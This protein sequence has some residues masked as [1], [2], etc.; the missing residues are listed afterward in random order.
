MKNH[1]EAELAEEPLVLAGHVAGR[2]KTA[3]V[4][5]DEKNFKEPKV[6]TWRTITCS[7][8]GFA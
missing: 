6:M 1:L 4:R 2:G 3:E 8:K 5:H 7:W